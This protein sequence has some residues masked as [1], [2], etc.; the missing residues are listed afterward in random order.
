M[1]LKS[2]IMAGIKRSL[3]DGPLAENL[4]TVLLTHKQIRENA[5]I[6]FLRGKNAGISYVVERIEALLNDINPGSDYPW[7]EELQS[8]RD[9]IVYLKQN[10]IPQTEAPKAPPSPDRPLIS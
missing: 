2:A 1:L 8:I 7:P 10:Q 9:H 6:N 3:N 5:A 4:R